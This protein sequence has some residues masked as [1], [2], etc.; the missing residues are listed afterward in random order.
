MD[1]STLA[2]Q[3]LCS[4]TLLLPETSRHQ[5]FTLIVY[6]PFG[7]I[8]AACRVL[9]HLLCAILYVGCSCIWTVHELDGF[10]TGLII[11]AATAGGIRVR[12]R[13]RN[14]QSV[15][16]A[17]LQLRQGR[18]LVCNHR[19]QLDALFLR[20]VSGRR[21][22]VPVRETYARNGWLI[23]QLTGMVVQPIWVPTPSAAPGTST[24][25][26]ARQGRADVLVAM[27]G[28]LARNDAASP[29]AHVPLLVFPEGSI[30]NG[31]GL[32][33]FARGAFALNEAV[34]LIALRVKCPLPLAHDTVRSSLLQNY[35]RTLFQPWL[36]VE[37]VLL[38]LLT[39]AAVEDPDAFAQRAAHLVAKELRVPATMH[40]TAD[41]A[42]LL[43]QIRA[44]GRVPA[45][46]ASGERVVASAT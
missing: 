27:R 29:A 17:R 8:I 7:V 21:L 1:D 26:Q 35:L 12:I 16:D 41:K 25:R 40:S 13:P 43:R 10:A 6:V 32:M 18:V 24:D 20:L 11:L 31:A 19:T 33:R 45:R 9:L 46:I 14:G 23:R 37:L 42:E 2:L 4:F 38:P 36:D 15:T 44:G 22:A 3:E 30:T 34:Q 5:L 28:H 39:P